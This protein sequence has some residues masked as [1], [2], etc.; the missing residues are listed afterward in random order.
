VL[1]HECLDQQFQAFARIRL[2]KRAL[3]ILAN[4]S[5]FGDVIGQR[6]KQTSF[7]LKLIV[8]RPVETLRWPRRYGRGISVAL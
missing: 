5:P 4:L 6:F 2:G 3:Q 1:R 8:D 7:G